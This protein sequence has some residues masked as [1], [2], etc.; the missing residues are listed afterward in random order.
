MQAK[1]KDLATISTAKKRH[2]KIGKQVTPKL[3]AK[4]AYGEWKPL[5]ANGLPLAF[6]ILEIGSIVLITKWRL[7]KF[8][9]TVTETPLELDERSFRLQI[10]DCT[11]SIASRRLR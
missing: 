3:L 1:E 8:V 5:L 2:S 6:S 11:S 4:P 9:F 10:V 7:Q